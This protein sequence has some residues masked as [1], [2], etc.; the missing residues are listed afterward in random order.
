MDNISARVVKAV[1]DPKARG[2]RPNPPTAIVKAVAD[3][4]NSKPK[5]DREALVILYE[6]ACATQ[7][8]KAL[9]AMSFKAILEEYAGY[10]TGQKTPKQQKSSMKLEDMVSTAKSA[11]DA[12]AK[13]AAER[14]ES[15]RKEEAMS[16]V[17]D[18][19]K[20]DAEAEAEIDEDERR[21]KELADS[22]LNSSITGPE[23]MPAPKRGKRK[24]RN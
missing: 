11:R 24:N 15:G 10:I 5:A 18:H 13:S 1:M 14:A 22:I 16:I 6:T 8:A 17:P 20:A 19:L 3:F 4:I 23:D 2:Y 7:P 9:N 12:L 21:R